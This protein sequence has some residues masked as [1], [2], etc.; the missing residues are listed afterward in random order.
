MVVDAPETLE[1]LVVFGFVHFDEDEAFIRATADNL[2]LLAEDH[3]EELREGYY[4][5]LLQT[6]DLEAA[7]VEAASVDGIIGALGS[8]EYRHGVAPVIQV[9][10]DPNKAALY[11]NIEFHEV[12]DPEGDRSCFLSRDC[13]RYAFTVF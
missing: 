9:Q 10:T 5:D 13:R 1:E 6:S 12:S 8:S 7:G 2:S 4:V 11:D 3:R